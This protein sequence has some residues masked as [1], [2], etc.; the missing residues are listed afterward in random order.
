MMAAPWPRPFSNPGWSFEP[1]LDGVRV[2]LHWDGREVELRTRRGRD[3]AV[4]YPELAGF[5]A[6]RPCVLDGEV[7]ALD[8]AGRP[9]FERLQQRMNVVDR[10]RV[11]AQAQAVPISYVV[12]D[13]LHDG[14]PLVDHPI[15]E[16]RARLAG[17]DLPAPCAP[18]QVVPGD[19]LALWE[20]V[21]VRGLEGMVAKRAASPYRPGARSP[22]WR[23]MANRHLVRAVV[24][25]YL[26]GDRGRSATFGSLLL[27]L[28]DGDRLRWIGAV[29]SGFDDATLRAVRGALDEM[30][31]DAAPFHPDATMWRNARWVEPAL[32]AVVEYKEWTSVGRL[33]APVFKGFATDPVEAITWEAEGPRSPAE[34]AGP[35]E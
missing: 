14:E 35:P 25:G 1:K 10:G 16:R 17:L 19:G 5:G 34:H 7:V 8:S 2:L 31:A 3:A 26:P 23:K 6:A 21:E 11:A 32:V 27:G 20:F 22:D 9:S 24:G 18:V 30:A 33:R 28:W 12:F 13:L 29:G 4:T 15:E